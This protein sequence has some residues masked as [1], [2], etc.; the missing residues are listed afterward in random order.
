M[1]GEASVVFKSVALEGLVENPSPTDAPS[2]LAALGR[3][4]LPSKA[5]D[6]LEITVGG[7]IQ[8]TDALHELLKLDGLNAL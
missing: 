2:N 8:L 3:Y 1:G 4:I 6:L 5:L 7:E